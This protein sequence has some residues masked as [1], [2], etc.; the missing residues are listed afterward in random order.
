M[1]FNL[2]ANMEKFTK[3]AEFIGTNVKGLDVNEASKICV[4]CKRAVK[5][6]RVASNPK[7]SWR[8]KGGYSWLVEMIFKWAN[9]SGNPR[10]V[11]KKQLRELYEKAY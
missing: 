5:R 11:S 4:S 1:E 9:E 6:H 10:E 7:R 8:K 3:I 2:S